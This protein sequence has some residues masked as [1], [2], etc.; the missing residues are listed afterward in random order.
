MQ[1]AARAH[2]SWLRI[3]NF[4]GAEVGLTGRVRAGEHDHAASFDGCFVAGDRRF[5]RA[6]RSI[7]GVRDAWS[8]GLVGC[9]PRPGWRLAGGWLWCAA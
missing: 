8:A 2:R 9:S 6:R 5:V 4:G 1:L 7:A 3:S